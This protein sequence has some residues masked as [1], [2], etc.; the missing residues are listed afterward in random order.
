[1]LT[2][3][4]FERFTQTTRCYHIARPALDT[5]VRGLRSRLNM[6]LFSQAIRPIYPAAVKR[7]MVSRTHIVLTRTTRIG[8]V[9]DR[10]G[11]SLSNIF[12]LKM[13]PAVTPCLLPHFFPRLVRGCPR[14]SVHIARVGARS[15]RRTLRT[16]SLSTKVVTDGLRSSFLARR[17]LFCRRFCTCMSHGRPSFGRRMVHASSVANRHL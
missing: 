1:M 12:H 4:R 8:S 17:A 5:V 3:S 9:V 2:I 11:R 16:K 7:G 15:V 10:S 13:L 6:G 14:L